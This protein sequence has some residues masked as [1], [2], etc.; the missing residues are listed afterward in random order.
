MLRVVNR[1][2]LAA[3]GLGMILL[4]VSALVGAA[5]LPR[6]WGF[7]LPS[8]WS[9]SSPDEVLLTGTDRTQWRDESWWWPVVLGVLALFVVLSLWWVLAQL[10]RRRLTE[11]SPASGEE[12]PD[13]SENNSVLRAHALEQVIAAET[14]ELAGVTRCRATLVGRRS[15]PR[16]RMLLSMDEHVVP[17]TVVHRLETE[18]LDRARSSANVGPLPAEIRLRATRHKARRVG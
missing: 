1:L 18:V 9:W 13:E 6:R 12:E 15:A 16:V 10:R 2:L 7:D 4:G 8:G 3:V 11:L 5:D 14:G 17:D